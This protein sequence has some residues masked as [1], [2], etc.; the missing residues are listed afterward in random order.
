MSIPD[1]K[2]PS[3]D[4]K[5]AQSAELW[6]ESPDQFL[7]GWDGEDLPPTFHAYAIRLYKAYKAV[8]ERSAIDALTKEEA[9]GLL[10]ACKHSPHCPHGW[11]D[12]LKEKLQ[13][14]ALSDGKSA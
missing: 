12:G 9:A 2:V 14:M 6:V 1:K 13:R 11:Y 7:D 4:L 5:H 8:S 10:E 3:L